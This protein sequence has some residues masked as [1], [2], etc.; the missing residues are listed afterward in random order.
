M[1]GAGL[2]PPGFHQEHTDMTAPSITRIDPGPRMSDAVIHGST[3]Y[4]AGQVADRAKGST[5]ADQTADILDQIDTLLAACGS[6]KANILTATIYLSNISTFAEMNAV[7]DV[8]VD[9]SNPPARA[10]VEARLAAPDYAVEI[11]V[12]AAR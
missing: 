6:S 10:T 12:I 7:W 2:A 5:V 9:K 8:W 11:V 3:I 4:C 1:F